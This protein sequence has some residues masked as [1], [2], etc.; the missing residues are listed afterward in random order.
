MENYEQVINEFCKALLNRKI[1]PSIHYE[2]CSNLFDALYVQ[3][4]NYYAD[5]DKLQKELKI[6]KICINVLIANIERK[7]TDPKIDN[8]LRIKYYELYENAYNLAARRSFKHFL[9]A[10][11]FKKR[12]KVWIQRINLFEPII[13]YLNK[14]ALDNDI[15]L[16]RA[17]MPPGYGKSYILTNFNAWLYGID[18][19]QAVMRIS[20]SDLLVKQFGRDV[21][22]LIKS[23]EFGK[24]FP[25]FATDRFFKKTED[26]FQFR[27]SR[28]RNYLCITR[29][30]RIVGFRTNYIIEDDLIGGTAEAMRPELH[31]S[32]INKH[33][34]DWT[35]RN[36]DKN[37]KVIALGTMFS[38]DDSLNWLKEQAEKSGTLEKSPFKRFVEVYRNTGTGRLEVFITIPA[39]DENDK[40]TLESEFPT[41]S[42]LKKRSE[43]FSDKSG[44]GVYFWNAVFMQTPTSPTG[45]DFGYDTLIKYEELPKHE[46]GELKLSSYNTASLDPARKGKNYVSMPIF[47][48]V[49]GVHY[50]ISCMFRKEPMTELYDVIVEKIIKYNIK[51]LY[52]EINTDTSLPTILRERLSKKGIAFCNIIE[53]YS[54]ENKEQRIKD[55][56]GHVKNTVAFPARKFWGRDLE[57]KAFME[58]LTSYSFDRPNKFDDA[59][60]A[61]VIYIMQ[62]APKFAPNAILEIYD[63]A[64]LGI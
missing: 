36:K 50:L 48:T 45:L 56:K 16:M 63:R 52:V 9:L 60:D 7:L 33:T 22:D 26:E 30:S 46:N 8:D 6:V 51:T 28:E 42:F 61:V 58:Q 3:F 64:M 13:Y 29:D 59:I 17:S 4:D 20:C 57:L 41:A 47:N 62:T 43:L 37:L 40:S 2:I 32:I 53:V 44:D 24:I 12:K 55:N 23:E 19:E 11:E 38:P 39:L 5:E 10:M 27:D 25:Y 34:T 35:T 1:E 18:Y 31:K 54:V 15:A 14:I 49:N 21:V